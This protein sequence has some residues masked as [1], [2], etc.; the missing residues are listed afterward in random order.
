MDSKVL[1]DMLDEFLDL[2][3]CYELISND[4]N[5]AKRITNRKQKIRI[6]IS[7]IRSAIESETEKTSNI[8]TC[9]DC[10]YSNDKG[11]CW[12]IKGLCNT[13]DPK[14]DF[15]PKPDKPT[16]EKIC[17]T[18]QIQYDIDRVICRKC[19]NGSKWTP[20]TPP[21]DDVVEKAKPTSYIINEVLS[22]AKTKV[23]YADETDKYT[24]SLEADN[25]KYKDMW[26]K[27]KAKYKGCDVNLVIG[28]RNLEEIMTELES[29]GE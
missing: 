16:V 5:F 2:Y 24:A 4:I 19:I 6:K 10:I 14:C 11:Y 17:E 13:L 27:L 21:K 26:E 9:N 25:K 23:Y 1:L 22:S 15:K 20:K 28:H 29:E 8:K 18:C 3:D 7:A 12:A